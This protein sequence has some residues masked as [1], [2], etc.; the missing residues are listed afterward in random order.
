MDHDGWTDLA[1]GRR[2]LLNRNGKLEPAAELPAPIDPI[3]LGAPRPKRWLQVA[4]TG[5]KNPKLAA[6]AKVEVKA[7]TLY[8][9]R[10]YEGVPLLFDLGEHA[11]ADTVRITWP[12]GL[13]QNET[14]QAGKSRRHVQGGAAPLRLLPDDL[15]L[16][17]QALPVHHRRPGRGAARRQLRATASIS[18][19]ITTSTSRSP[20][21]RSGRR[22]GQY[23][24]RITEELREVAYLDQVRLDRASIIRRGS[25]SSPTTSSRRRRSPSS[26]CSA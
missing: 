23:E 21:S 11:S 5:V 22:D 3:D 2:L 6:N 15:H 8:E 4:L 20:A 19:W 13:I 9:K 10:T 25:R 17:R 1:A 7:G 26:G 12:N 18:R 24:I 16:E 14:K